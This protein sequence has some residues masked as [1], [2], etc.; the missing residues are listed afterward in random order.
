RLWSPTTR[1]TSAAT[2]FPYTTLFRS[3][4][5]HGP[6]PIARARDKMDA[7]FEFITKLGVPYFCFHDFDLIEE[8][9]TLAESEERLQ[10]ITDYARDRKSTRLNSSHVKDSYA[11]CCLKK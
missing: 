6:D 2:L 4:W 7:A 3:P 5:L 9:G 11:V 10:L 8:G 1:P